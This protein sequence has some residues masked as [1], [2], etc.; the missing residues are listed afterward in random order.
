VV[1][2]W[3]GTG[4]SIHHYQVYRRSLDGEDWTALYTLPA[5]L[6]DQDLWYEFEDSGV[7][8]GSYVYGVSAIAMNF[9]TS[10]PSPGLESHVKE[11][12]PIEVP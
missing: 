7:T 4:A 9:T 12:A 8:N 2:E 3:R 1:I 6:D 11:T 5:I 10:P